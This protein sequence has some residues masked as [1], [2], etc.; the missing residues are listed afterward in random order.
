MEELS[1]FFARTVLGSISMIPESFI[2]FLPIIIFVGFISLI[3]YVAYYMEKKRKEEMKNYAL[4]AGFY[5]EED[6]KTLETLKSDYNPSQMEKYK[7]VYESDPIYKDKLSLFSGLFSKET[8]SLEFTGLEFF[9]TGHSKK[10]SNLI[11]I[12]F[13]DNRIMLFDYKYTVG[14]G[15]HSTT[16][17]HTL[18]FMK[19]KDE[20]PDFVLRPENFFDKI[21]S[22]LGFKDINFDNYPQFSSSYC[23][24][25]QREES[26]RGFFNDSRISFFQSE[27][28]WHC[29]AGGRFFCAY[30]K[31]YRLEIKEIPAFIEDAK[32][33]F[34]LLNLN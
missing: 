19:T 10:A 6:A 27:P 31:S 9:R 29:H 7:S 34:S 5:Y 23:L 28:G 14:S 24:K 11:M 20:V 22:F 18:A 1:R 3:F 30:K 25:G 21:G 17:N 33:L 15:K 32:R 12:P 16:Y 8:V 4:S 2:P 26:V 13:K